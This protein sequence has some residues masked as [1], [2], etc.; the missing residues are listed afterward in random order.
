MQDRLEQSLAALVDR[1]R[2]EFSGLLA[3][4]RFGSLGTGYGPPSPVEAIAG[5]L[6]VLDTREPRKGSIRRAVQ[7]L[8]GARIHVLGAVT[9]NVRVDKDGYYWHRYGHA[10]R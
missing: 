2:Q 3:V 7:S 9:K 10:S 4:Y 1:L 6:P 8:Q 5:T